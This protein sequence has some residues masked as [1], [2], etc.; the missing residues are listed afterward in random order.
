M[1]VRSEKI[2]NVINYTIFSN[3]LMLPQTFLKVVVIVN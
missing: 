2:V 3:V 1:N